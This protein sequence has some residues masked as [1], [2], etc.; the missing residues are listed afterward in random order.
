MELVSKDNG[1][2]PAVIAT[3]MLRW[4]SVRYWVAP[5]VGK[6]REG[7]LGWLLEKGRAGENSIANGVDRPNQWWLN[8]MDSDLKASR[9][10]P[11]Q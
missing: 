3:K 4:N 6:L 11:D 2:R 1:R 5:I 10:H 7:Y 8:T 9:L